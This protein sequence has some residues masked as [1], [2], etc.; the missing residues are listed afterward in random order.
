MVNVSAEMLEE[1]IKC[2]LFDGNW[3][4]DH[5]Q[6]PMYR[7]GSC[8]FIDESFNCFHNK[9]PDNGYEKYRWQPKHCKIPRYATSFVHY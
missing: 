4:E 9:R 2:D 1:L 8:P 5:D 6:L 3:V 7:P